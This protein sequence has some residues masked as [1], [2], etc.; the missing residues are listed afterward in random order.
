VYVFEK[1]EVFDNAERALKFAAFVLPPQKPVSDSLDNLFEAHEY[2]NAVAAMV[3]GKSN[4][5]NDQYIL[6]GG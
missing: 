1:G 6:H 5:T 2:A 4:G 3:S